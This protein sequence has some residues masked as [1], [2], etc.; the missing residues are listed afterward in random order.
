[1]KDIVYDRTA[2]TREELTARIMHAATEIKDSR[3]QLRFISVRQS[4]HRSPPVEV[5]RPLYQA[6]LLPDFRVRESS[7]RCRWSCGFSRGSLVLPALAFPRFTII[8]SRVPIPPEPL[9]STDVSVT[10]NLTDIDRRVVDDSEPIADLQGNKQRVPYCQVWSDTG[11]SLGL[12]PMNKHLKLEYARGASILTSWRGSQRAERAATERR[13]AANQVSNKYFCVR[14]MA[15]LG[16][17]I[18]WFAAEKRSVAARSDHLQ[19]RKSLPTS[20]IGRDLKLRNGLACKTLPCASFCL[21]HRGMSSAASLMTSHMRG[22]GFASPSRLLLRPSLCRR[23]H[24]WTSIASLYAQASFALRE[25]DTCSLFARQERLNF[26]QDPVCTVTFACKVEQRAV[27]LFVTDYCSAHLKSERSLCELETISLFVRDARECS[28]SVCSDPIRESFGVKGR[29]KRNIPEKIRRPAASSGLIPTCEN[30]A[31]T[32]PEIDSVILIAIQRLLSTFLQLRNALPVNIGCHGRK[33]KPRLSSGLV[34]RLAPRR[35]GG[36]GVAPGFDAR[37]NLRR[38]SSAVFHFP[39]PAHSSAAP[40]IASP[41]SAL[42]ISMVERIEHGAAP[43]RMK[44][45]GG[46]DPRENLPT[47]GIVR[48]GPHDAKISRVTT[49]GVS[50]PWGMALMGGEWSNH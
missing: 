31:A 3:L 15:T 35:T 39:P 42:K 49:A 46:G 16:L 27:K 5:I 2:Q 7:R 9:N 40:Y 18:P 50:R 4:P 33:K 6:V 30:P 19:L 22:C 47:S 13:S 21:A 10:T 11:H 41:S 29:G 17:T 23:R 8:V 24:V 45:G 43:K 20:A 36:G 25:C 34:T 28:P 14:H 1:M 32:P 12:Q 48:H 26:V 44:R 38:E 37:E